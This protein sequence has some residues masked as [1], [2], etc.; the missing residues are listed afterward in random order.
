MENSD[1]TTCGFVFLKFDTLGPGNRGHA[2]DLIDWLVAMEE[3]SRTGSDGVGP[4]S[5]CKIPRDCD[6]YKEKHREGEVCSLVNTGRVC[7]RDVC[8]TGGFFDYAV[9]VVCRDLESLENLVTYCQR[10]GPKRGL[11]SETQT[12][13]ARK[14]R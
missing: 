1:W 8:V 6:P 5:L 13:V 10:C 9:F 14:L 12:V 7:V 4:I 3:Q 11:I 2:Q